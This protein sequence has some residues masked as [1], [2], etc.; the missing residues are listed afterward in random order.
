M[1]HNSGNRPIH[2]LTEGRGPDQYI[3]IDLV[4]KH[5]ST[6]NIFEFHTRTKIFR[7]I[8]TLTMSPLVKWVTN[9]Y[10]DLTDTYMAFTFLL[11]N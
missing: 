4:L 2:T 8:P 10:V 11:I 3:H 7:F 5:T 6:H 9:A 1:A